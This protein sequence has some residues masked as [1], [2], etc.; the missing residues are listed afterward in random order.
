MPGR[1][2]GTDPPWCRRDGGT[3]LLELYVQPGARATGPAGMHGG[4]LKLR[5][6]APARD[7][8]ANDALIRLIS[9]RLGVP[10]GRVR[11]VRGHRG[12][13]KTVAVAGATG[14]PEALAEG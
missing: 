3:L 10:A 9:D 12:R 13:N 5:I 7:G 14:P 1:R 2:A 11:L 8:R 4:R 6:A